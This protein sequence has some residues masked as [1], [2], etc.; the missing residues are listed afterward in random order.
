MRE[1]AP[2]DCRLLQLTPPC[3]GDPPEEDTCIAMYR[4]STHAPSWGR[5]CSGTLFYIWQ[6]LQLTP[7]RGGELNIWALGAD[8]KMLQFTPPCGANFLVRNLNH[9]QHRFN[10]R[11]M[12][13]ANTNLKE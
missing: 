13:G 10:S 7:H 3:G 2:H 8:D 11:P 6:A 4:A 1:K 9:N 12:W 5:T